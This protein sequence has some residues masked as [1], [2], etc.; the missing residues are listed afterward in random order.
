LKNITGGLISMSYKL[1]NEY[2]NK[3]IQYLEKRY[4]RKRAEAF[5][6]N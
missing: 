3:Y 2:E 5:L 1:K 4:S 6:N